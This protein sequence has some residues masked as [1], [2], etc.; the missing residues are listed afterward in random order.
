[1]DISEEIQTDSDLIP[2][3]LYRLRKN[4][5]PEAIKPLQLSVLQD[6]LPKGD[7]FTKQDCISWDLAI[8]DFGSQHGPRIN[9]EARSLEGQNNM[10]L[11]ALGRRTSL[12]QSRTSSVILK[13]SLTNTSRR[14]HHQ[15]YQEEIK[16]DLFGMRTR[17]L[18]D[19]EGNGR[20][21][22]GF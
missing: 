3:A 10:Q 11:T 1:M 13:K 18:K 19:P 5:K 6:V 8:R 21:R 14:H 2:P 16:T 20:R 22:I 15:L 7:E 17:T 9:Q 12:G 4:M